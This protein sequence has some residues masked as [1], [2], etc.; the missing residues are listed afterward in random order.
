[1][2]RLTTPTY[3]SHHHQLKALWATDPRPFAD[4]TWND[5]LDLHRYYLLTLDKTEAELIAHRH[6]VHL[7]DPSLP[8]RAGRAYAKLMRGEKA[9]VGYSVSPSGH[10]ITV[11]VLAW[12]EPDVRMLAKIFWQMALEDMKHE[13]EDADKDEAA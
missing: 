11:R 6:N 7:G 10:R 3:L 8:Q 5:Q 4:L 13:D 9:P 1:M 2:P 12:P